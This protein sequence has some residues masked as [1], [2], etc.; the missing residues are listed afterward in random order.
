[1]EETTNNPMYDEEWDVDLGGVLPGGDTGQA[2]PGP[3]DGGGTDQAAP[4]GGP[5]E[6]PEETPDAPEAEPGAAGTPEKEAPSDLLTLKHM[7]SEV[8][9]DRQRATELAQM[10]LD[11]DRV[12]G[13]RDEFRRQAEEL[14]QYQAET[15][16]LV[17]FLRDLAKS[18]GMSPQQLMD[19]VRV[20]QYVQQD[21]VSKE[22]ARERVAR[23][24]AERRLQA[25]E[26]GRL[27]GLSPQERMQKDIREFYQ[28]FPDVRPQEID[29]SVWDDVRRGKPLAGA[30]QDF[31][32]RKASREK[33]QEIQ[34]LRSELSAR[35]QNRDN[36]ARTIGSQRTGALE[37]GRDP[38]LEAFLSDD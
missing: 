7:G 38:F 14:R 10:G 26:A 21:N 2:A 9:V 19:E 15:S 24:K 1:M 25:Q 16:E 33:D 18:S 35:N 6:E 28:S 20:N 4:G 22:T 13:Q 27:H 36:R 17:D 23:E 3:Q 5:E 8:Q 29:Q 32:Y 12:R 37:N 30:Y 31:L 11:Y 34:R